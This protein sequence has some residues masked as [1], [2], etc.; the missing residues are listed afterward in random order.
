[1]FRKF[2]NITPVLESLFNKVA[3]LKACS[4]IK[5]RLQHRCFPVVKFAKFLRT[6]FFY[7]IPFYSDSFCMFWKS[8][9]SFSPEQFTNPMLAGNN[10][11][12]NF[13]AEVPVGIFQNV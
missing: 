3:G 13:T 5:N 4:F 11:I 9:E 2:H 8:G 6:L 1:M 10:F 7:K 12:E